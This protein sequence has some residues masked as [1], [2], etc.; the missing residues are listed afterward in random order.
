MNLNAKKEKILCGMLGVVVADA[1]ALG[2]HWIYDIN[3]VK[4]VGGDA[5]EFIDPVQ[6]NYEGVPSYFAHPGKQSGDNSHYGETFLNAARSIANNGGVFKP[7]IYQRDYQE[8]FGPGGH[9][10][11]YIDHPTKDTLQNLKT[12]EL[13]AIERVSAD[14]KDL[15]RDLRE[16]LTMKVLSVTKNYTGPELPAKIEEAVR[17][18]HDDDK[19]VKVALDM[20][21]SVDLTIPLDSGAY[22]DQI[23]ALAG[24]LSL[25]ASGNSNLSDVE[26]MVKITNNHEKSVAAGR[27]FARLLLASIEEGT[28]AEA[29]KRAKPELPANWQESTQKAM[30]QDWPDDEALIE[31]F[32]ASC[33]LRYSLPVGLYIVRTSN[34]YAEAVRKN[35]RLSGDSCGRSL[36]T[37]ALAG[38][39][40]G[41]GGDW[42]IPHLWLWKIKEQERK[43]RPL[44]QLLTI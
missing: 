14:F 12:A 33:P 1:A 19:I 9:F 7:R 20:A 34:S 17:I 26:V 21:K 22:D 35:I 11:G 6:K 5:P 3:R 29:Y 4:D 44:W 16:T 24:V 23:P 10:R 37:G 40:W 13:K 43:L 30:T 41:I 15:D 25:I 32:G 8:F 31:E 39:R 18:T 2:L 42:G 27:F 36:L 38:I 28:L